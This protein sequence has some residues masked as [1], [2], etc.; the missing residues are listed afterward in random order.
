LSQ[1]K[2]IRKNLPKLF[3]RKQDAAKIVS[4]EKL[5]YEN[6]RKLSV[7]NKKIVSSEPNRNLGSLISAE[8]LLAFNAGKG[9]KIIGEQRLMTSTDLKKSSCR[10]NPKAKKVI[11]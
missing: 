6:G 1:P 11:N 4:H 8:P 10:Q 7:H 5:L 3:E 2:K 9:T